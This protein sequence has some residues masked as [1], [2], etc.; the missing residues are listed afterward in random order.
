MCDGYSSLVK[1]V[2]RNFVEVYPGQRPAFISRASGRVEL[3]GGHTD[4]NDGFVIAAAI[5]NS[6]RV[7]ASERDDDKIC[8]Y[9]ELVKEEHEFILSSNLEPADD[10]RWANYGRGVAAMLLQEGLTLRG[11]NLYIASEVP[12]GAGLSS[13]AALEVSLARAM[14]HISQ[15]E[16]EMEPIRLAQICQKAENSYANSPCGIMDQTVSIMGRKDHAVFLDCRDVSVKALPFDSGNCCIMIFNSMVKHEIGGG[17]YGRRRQKCEQACAVLNKK[18]PQVKAL[19]DANE[20][21]LNSV[22]E[23]L[24]SVT[25]SR[26]SHVIG[27][28]ARVLAAGEAL[29]QNNIAEFGRLMSKSHC[30]ARDLYQIS[31]EQTDFLAEQIWQCEGAYGAR[32]MGGGFGGSV[33]ALAEPDAAEKISQKVRKAYKNSFDIDGDIYLARPWQGTEIIELK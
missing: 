10:C 16:Y 6:C 25:F 28:N 12:I 2:L 32:I 33:V 17:E 22:K 9:S 29:S 26:A 15:P 31:C 11:A 5:D 30:S 27:E 1:E 19:R 4:Y 8:L 7:A 21:M 20:S 13:S 23:Q 3:I 18:Y 24:D 14:I